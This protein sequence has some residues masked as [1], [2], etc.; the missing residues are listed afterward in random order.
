MYPCLDEIKENYSDNTVLIV[1][2]ASLMRVLNSYF[3]DLT[4][5]EFFQFNVD[6]CQ[7]VEYE[8]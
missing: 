4:N 8:L 5:E 1:S 3:V 7:L 6:N 2:H